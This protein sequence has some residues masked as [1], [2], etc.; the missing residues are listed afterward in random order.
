MYYLYLQNNWEKWLS[1]TEFTV[2][3]VENKITKVT[4]FFANYKQHSQLEFKSWT[5]IDEY[6]PMIKQL[7]Q[8][9]ANNFT[10]QISKLTKLLWSEMLYTQALQEYHVNKKR[11]PAYDFKSDNKVYLST[12]NLRTQWFSKKLDW[13]FI[14]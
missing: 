13:K 5:E 1:L 14:E 8:I 4:S 11:L 7:Q 6:G 9:D 10:D 2:N 12:Q 3:N